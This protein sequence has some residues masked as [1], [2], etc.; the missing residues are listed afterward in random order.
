MLFRSLRHTRTTALA[1]AGS[2]ALIAYEVA[3]RLAKRPEGADL[4]PHV[5]DIKRLLG[6]RFGNRKKKSA[7]TPQPAPHVPAQTSPVSPSPSTTAPA[8]SQPKAQPAASVA[9]A[10]DPGVTAPVTATKSQ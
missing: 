8:S 5:A 7:Q 1:K 3:K 10:A 2:V 4:R 9:G 6:S